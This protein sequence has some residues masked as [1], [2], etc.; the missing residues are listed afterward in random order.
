M[1][2]LIKLFIFVLVFIGAVACNGSNDAAEASTHKKNWAQLV[3]ATENSVELVF[4][5]S[6]N[7]SVDL[8]LSNEIVKSGTDDKQYEFK[9]VDENNNPIEGVVGNVFTLS[10]AVH[11]LDIRFYPKSKIALTAYIVVKRDSEFI[12]QNSSILLKVIDSVDFVTVDF[13]R[14]IFYTNHQGSIGHHDNLKAD[15]TKVA[16][17][18][19]NTMYTINI[20]DD[21]N[22]PFSKDIVEFSSSQFKKNSSVIPDITVTSNSSIEPQ[23]FHFEVVKQ[24]PGKA[25]LVLE[26][27]DKHYFRVL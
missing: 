18:D 10:K 12:K 13:V 7:I 19:D 9:L 6:R 26:M 24:E 15:F 11:H 16:S 20:V 3:V 4:G 27:K 1:K 17:D 25:K 5:Q 2:N 14:Y 22:K 8:N 21:N 23:C